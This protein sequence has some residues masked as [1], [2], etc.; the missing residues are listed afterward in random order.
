MAQDL[1]YYFGEDEAFFRT[2]QGEFKKHTKLSFRFERKFGGN[3][4]Q[5]Q[6]LFLLISQNKPKCVFIDFSK[7]TENYLHLARLIARTNFSEKPLSVGLVDYLS[8][9]EVM[10]ESISTGINLTHIKSAETYD[11]V[12]DVASL[13]APDSVQHGFATAEFTETWEAGLPA[14][15]GYVTK[16]GIHFETDYKTAKGD[17]ILVNHQWSKEKIVPSRELFVTDSSKKNLFYHFENAVDAEFVFI[18]EFVPAE[19]MDEAVIKEKRDFRDD[20]VKR[21]KKKL[22]SWIDDNLSRSFEK[23]MKLLII[24]QEFRFLQGQKR[25]DKYP[26]MIRCAPYLTDIAE[27]LN[28]LCPQIIAV[29]LEKPEIKDAKNDFDFIEKLV[30]VVKRDHAETS[31][32]IIVFNTKITTKELREQLKYEHMMTTDGELE[33][34]VLIKMAE[35]LEKKTAEAAKKKMTA[36]AEPKVYLKKSNPASHAI[37]MMNVTILSLSETDMVFTSDKD[38]T[39]GT[40]LFFEKPVPFFV[41]VQPAKGAKGKVAEYNGL[42]HCIG[43]SD[44]K[45]LRKYVNSIF[46]RDHDE[47]HGEELQQFKELND[48]KLKEKLEAIRVAQEKALAE[49]EAKKAEEAAKAAS[50]AS[51]PVAEDK[52]KA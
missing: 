4:S 25:T 18:D 34:D 26:Y 28:R 13:L 23:P 29:A 40:N 20:Q 52:E 44:K 31:P 15:I 27:D 11:C 17:R 30:N 46:F 2:L 49:A 38:L 33:P 51:H 35:L 43:E 47:K 12:F 48:I 1:F 19:G 9:P 16:A 22:S 36:P 45:E 14:K 39:P 41:N 42:I 8:P 21:H 10:F 32:Y 7:E 3:E 24:D 6:A 37:I 5:I 50:A